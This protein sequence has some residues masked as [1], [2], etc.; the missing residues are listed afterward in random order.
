[1]GIFE[2]LVIISFASIVFLFF[3][4]NF[5]YK[6]LTSCLEKIKEITLFNEETSKA[7]QDIKEKVSEYSIITENIQENQE[8]L[9]KSFQTLK[10]TAIELQSA[11]Q[12]KK[13]VLDLLKTKGI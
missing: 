6:E 1:M 8:N 5:L 2:T 10:E 7:I 13:A 4:F 12:S 3:L 11:H 9:N